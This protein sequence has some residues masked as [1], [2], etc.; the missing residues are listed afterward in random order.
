LLTKARRGSRIGRRVADGIYAGAHGIKFVLPKLAQLPAFQYGPNHRGA[1]IRWQRPVRSCQLPP[2]R[3][4]KVQLDCNPAIY[5][6]CNVIERMFCRFK[7][8]RRVA[9]RFDRNIKT[10]M[11]SIAIDATEI[12]WL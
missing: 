5:K 3:H 10:F 12:W 8:W 9:T 1:M 7:D 4:R 11:A 6:Q 2:K